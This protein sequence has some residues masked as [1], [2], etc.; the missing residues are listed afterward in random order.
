MRLLVFEFITG[1]G[2][3]GDS[4][5]DSLRREGEM[6]RNA[7]LDDLVECPE[8]DVVT[9][10]DR[11]CAVPHRHGAAMWR[12]PIDAENT[13]TF[14]H[15]VLAEVDVVWLIAPETGGALQ[16]LAQT[17][18]AAG[19]PVLLSDAAALALCSSKYETYCAL[20]RA[21]INAIE[22]FRAADE[23]PEI[24]GPWLVKPDDGAG[25]IGI[26][27]LAS[28]G[29]ARQ[30]LCA[31]R[32]WPEV[33][34]GGPRPAPQP[35]TSWP[36]ATPYPRVLQPWCE[37]DALSL[38]LLGCNGWA[39]LLSVN[40]QHVFL[41][42]GRV[43]VDALTVNALP[44]NSSDFV[45]LAQQVANAL[46]GLWGYVGVDLIRTNG[47]VLTVLEINPRL[48]TSYCGLRR[49]LGINVVDLVLK[50]FHKRELPTV[51]GNKNEAV[52]L[53]LAMDY[54]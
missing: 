9:M 28:I 11:R 17:A 1:G 47:G 8:I 35:P 50:Q 34:L 18:R 30:A 43:S 5:P 51:V 15:R 19:K 53:N 48:T 13:M 2:L 12:A 29:G 3:L 44:R 38:S 10:R 37:G 6:M 32:Q 52:E 22:T 14:Y 4:L 20:R 49:A 31:D 33:A 39:A 46:P 26:E 21:G 40:R 42:N 25:S 41:Q 36:K 45:L 24:A 16:W 23:L 54:A 7:L 27:L